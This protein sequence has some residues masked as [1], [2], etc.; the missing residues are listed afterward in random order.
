MIIS[1]RKW[2]DFKKSYQYD[3]D[4]LRQEIEGQGL[5][6]QE[7]NKLCKEILRSIR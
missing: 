7:S 4:K 1:K 3:M 5:R 6:T 2:E